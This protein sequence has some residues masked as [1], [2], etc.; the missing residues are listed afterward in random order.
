MAR[1]ASITQAEVSA[2]ADRIRASGGKPTAR[3]IR[4][5][6]GTGSM[7]TVLRLLQNWQSGQVK[8]PAREVVLPAGLQKALVDFVG[9]EVVAA[10]APIQEELASAQQSIRDLISEN[11][12]QTAM[13]ADQAEKIAALTTQLDQVQAVSDQRTKEFEQLTAEIQHERAAVQDARIELAKAQLR[14]ESL[15]R[16]EAECDR[17]R[18][19]LEAEQKARTASDLAAAVATARL[20]ER[21]VAKSLL[22]SATEPM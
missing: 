14:M 17:L 20:E 6:L 4:E 12:S 7:A 1:E 16:L 18:D 15:P 3:S 19:L 5:A 9:G 10:K 22:P 13:I 11:E 21:S 2:E 8:P